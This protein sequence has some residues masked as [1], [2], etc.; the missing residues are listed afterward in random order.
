MISDFLLV[1]TVVIAIL[2][3][4]IGYWRNRK[5]ATNRKN[6]SDTQDNIEETSNNYQLQSELETSIA[7]LP[8]AI[9]L[10]EENWRIEW[11]NETAGKW[12]EGPPERSLSLPLWQGIH[13]SGLE[14]YLKQRNFRESFEFESPY[15]PAVYLGL[16]IVPYRKGHFIAI[17]RDISKIKQLEQIRRDFVANAS[18][19]L[20]TPLSILYG[21]L[22]M[23]QEEPTENISKTWQPAVKQMFEQTSRIKQIVDDMMLLSRLEDDDIESDHQYA[24]ISSLMEAAY[25]DAVALAINKNHRISKDIDDNYSLLCNPTQ[26][27][28]LVINLISNA[29]RYTPDNGEIKISWKVDLNG[30][31]VSVKDTGIG[32]EKVNI[33]RLTERFYRS[34]A[35]RSRAT[36]GTGLGLAI[37]NHIVQGHKAKLTVDSQIGKGS[38]FAVTFPTNLIRADHQQVNLLLK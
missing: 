11:V 33:P 35:A 14:L 1:L 5:T 19:E 26:I 38:E 37:V 10:L 24:E 18:H 2:I 31:T 21:Y 3:V 20:R 30:G 22:E 16:R 7:S 25:K 12:L 29:I 34:D 32:I 36:G 13:V 6:E 27:Q 23:M 4:T 28:S 15:D 9:F 17:G 8:D